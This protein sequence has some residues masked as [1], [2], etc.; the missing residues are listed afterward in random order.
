MDSVLSQTY[1]PLELIVVDDGSTDNTADL[2]AKYGDNVRY[3]YQSNAGVSVARNK[4]VD[5]AKGDWLAFLDADDWYYPDRLKLH[6]EW[7]AREPGMDF[8]TGDFDYIRP[9]GSNIRRSMETTEAGAIL[10]SKKRNNNEV[11]MEGELI[12]KFIEHHFGDTHTLSLPR[13]TFLSLG[14]YPVGIAVCEDVNFLIR[15]CAES[16]KVGVVCQPMAAYVIHENSATRVDPVKAQRQTIDALL[17]LRKQIQTTKSIIQKGLAGA[18]RHARLD[19]AYSLLK[20]GKRF[21]ALKA[22]L[23]LLYEHPGLKSVRDLASIIRG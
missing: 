15:L 11:I 1:A 19:Y 2:V 14:G 22:V 7:I 8:L 10:F 16:V 20:T 21:A 17:P 5:E 13:K 18:I 9:N 6:A 23:P 4:G 3:I 12:G